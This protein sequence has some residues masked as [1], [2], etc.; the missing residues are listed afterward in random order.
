M[1]IGIGI[2]TFRRQI[3]VNRCLTHILQNTNVGDSS[4]GRETVISIVSDSEHPAQ[5]MG[6]AAAKNKCLN[7]LKDCDHVFLFD[8]DCWPIKTGWM[9]LFIRSGEDHLIFCHKSRHKV[10]AERSAK[11][12]GTIDLY[13]SCGGVMLYLSKAAIG[14]VG[15]MNESFGLYGFEHAEY[16]M[17]I[18]QDSYFPSI[19]GAEQY[20]YSADY[21]DPHNVKSSLNDAEKQDALAKSRDV[22][23][24]KPK[25]IYIPFA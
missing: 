19:R 20:L 21:E 24:N 14:R 18:L 12:I 15:A 1:R 23:Y 7:T 13:D 16:S 25:S 2:T 8:D 11:G 10:I 4:L 9:D 17:R 5:R 22:F 6:V 3:I